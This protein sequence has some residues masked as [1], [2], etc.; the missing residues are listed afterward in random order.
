MRVAVEVVVGGGGVADHL[1]VVVGEV[2]GGDCGGGGGRGRG[3]LIGLHL[4]NCWS[5][6]Y[7]Y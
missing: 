3:W 5:V 1:L 2:V 6:E 7:L 4:I